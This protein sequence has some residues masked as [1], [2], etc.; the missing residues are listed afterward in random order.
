MCSII[1]LQK[2]INNKHGSNTPTHT[3][4][5]TALH[6][7]APADEGSGLRAEPECYQSPEWDVQTQNIN[8]SMDKLLQGNRHSSKNSK[9]KNLRVSLKLHTL[10]DNKSNQWINSIVLKPVNEKPCI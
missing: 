2:A 8:F 1:P 10:N 6:S 7:P 3:L 4:S 9:K 5:N